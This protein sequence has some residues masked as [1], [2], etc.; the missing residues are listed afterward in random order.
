VQRADRYGSLGIEATGRA[1]AI[2]TRRLCTRPGSYR[3]AASF[4]RQYQGLAYPDA[5][6]EQHPQQQPVPQ[7]TAGIQDQ[8]RLRR[9]QHPGSGRRPG[10]YLP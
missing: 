1:R 2:L 5:G 9:G 6:I 10:R 7:V 8:L 4:L 3:Y